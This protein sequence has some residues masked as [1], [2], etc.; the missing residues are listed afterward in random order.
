MEH[1]KA[2]ELRKAGQYDQAIAL[3]KP[4]WE[5]KKDLFDGAG[6]LYCYRKN[7]DYSEAISVA[8]YI[9]RKYK[10][11]EKRKENE[12]PRNE[13]VWVYIYGVLNKYD[14]KVKISDVGVMLEKILKLEPQPKDKNKAILKALKLAKDADEW[15]FVD[16]F[17]QLID[18][19]TLDKKPMILIDGREGWSQYATWL[20][21]RIQGLLENNN[22]DGAIN[23]LEKEDLK[24][25]PK[26]KR[27]FLHLKGK[28]YHRKGLNVEASEIYKEISSGQKPDCWILHE[29]ALVK[30]ALAFREEALSMLYQAANLGNDL[31]FMVNIFCDIGD[32]CV[33]LSKDEIARAHY[34]LSKYIRIDQ[35]WRVSETL[36]NKISTVNKKIGAEKEPKSFQEALNM[37]KQEWQTVKA[38]AVSEKAITG[39]VAGITNERP[40]CFINGDDKRVFFCF[41]TDLPK[42]IINGSKVRFDVVSSFDKKKNKEGWKALN[43]TN[44]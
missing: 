3:Y 44:M 27:H 24:Q 2:K 16:K 4:I 6:L 22:L 19:L 9:S 21:Y 32:I 11:I 33:E 14:E 18:S 29:F 23:I 37:C 5:E 20:N 12:W 43:I 42:G 41:K 7:I 38:D 40:Y 8:D 10:D 1:Q 17:A 36:S 30:K 31:K 28:S 25:F 35:G 13:A 39:S 26:Q 15:V 34:V